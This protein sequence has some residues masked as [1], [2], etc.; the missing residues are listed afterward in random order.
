MQQKSLRMSVLQAGAAVSFQ[1][2]SCAFSTEAKKKKMEGGKAAA[3]AAAQLEGLKFV[4]WLFS[5]LFHSQW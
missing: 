4:R 5:F 2:I 3:A 1:F